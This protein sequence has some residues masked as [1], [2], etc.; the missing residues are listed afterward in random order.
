ML[1]NDLTVRALDNQCCICEFRNKD[2]DI[3]LEE[4]FTNTAL[5]IELNISKQAKS[6]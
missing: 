6:N 1:L 3:H 2:S 5:H 4:L